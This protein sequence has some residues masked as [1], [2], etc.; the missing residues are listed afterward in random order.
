MDISVPPASGHCRADS[1]GLFVHAA[2]TSALGAPFRPP[3]QHWPIGVTK[4][5]RGRLPPTPP[6]SRLNGA[7]KESVMTDVPSEMPDHEP[8]EMPIDPD[9]EMPAQ[10]GE[11]PGSLGDEALA[12]GSDVGGDAPI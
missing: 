8:D 6:C 7:T 9:V 1:V 4:I 12:S 3:E 2:L 5:S 10:P 11:D